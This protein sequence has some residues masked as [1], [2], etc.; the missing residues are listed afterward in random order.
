MAFEPRRLARPLGGAEQ[1]R[2]WRIKGEDCLR[3]Q[4]ELRNPRETRVTQGT[5]VAGTDPGSPSSLATFFLATQEEST[6][7]RQARKLAAQK[8]LKTGKAK[9][10]PDPPGWLNLASPLRQHG[11]RASPQTGLLRSTAK[12]GQKSKFQR[13]DFEMPAQL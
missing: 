11:A 12:K 4:P 2:G 9:P 10:A 13:I 5:G 3:A 8:R 6:P 7:A 1:R